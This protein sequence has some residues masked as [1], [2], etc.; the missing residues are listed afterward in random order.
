M[1]SWQLNWGL[2]QNSC[3]HFESPIV[4]ST[5]Y[6]D[7][8]LR[9]KRKNS[10]EFKANCGIINSFNIWLRE[11]TKPTI[12]GM[13]FCPGHCYQTNKPCPSFNRKIVF[14]GTYLGYLNGNAPC[15]VFPLDR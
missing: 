5:D 13:I 9:L 4:I 7:M 15:Y 11:F 12:C 3:C 1:M 14:F 10:F 2:A 8:P 6:N